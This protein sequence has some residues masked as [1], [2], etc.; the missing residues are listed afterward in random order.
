MPLADPPR[1]L[2]EFGD[3][4][5]V[6]LDLCGSARQELILYDQDFELT[7]L[8]SRAGNAALEALCVRTRVI[9]GVRILVRSPRFIERDCPRLQRLLQQFGHRI[10]VRVVRKGDASSDQP[11]IVNDNTG[12]VLRFHHDSMR[13]KAHTAD[14]ETANRLIAQFETMW[15]NAT[16]GPNGATLGL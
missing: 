14:S 3:Y 11:F 15:M 9:H 16:N 10:V 12:Y 8:E 1:L 6:A 7:G 2:A 5:E 13:G 4:R